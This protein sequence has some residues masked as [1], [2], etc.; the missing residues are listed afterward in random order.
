MAYTVTSLRIEE[1]RAALAEL[2][3]ENFDEE[4]ILDY[5]R[6]RFSWLYENSPETFT[7][8]WLAVQIEAGEVVGC[9]SAFRANRFFR[10][11]CFQGCVPV[12]FAVAGGH[13]LSGWEGF[14][15]RTAC[16]SG[17]RGRWRV[18]LL[19]RSSTLGHVRAIR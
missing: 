11:R 5:L 9:G 12:V 7:R 2:W 14:P 19:V 15:V 6:E 18:R 1:H 17:R 16:V 3:R 8:T 10:G 4:E 13:R